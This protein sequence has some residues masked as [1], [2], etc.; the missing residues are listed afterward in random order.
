MPQ[1]RQKENTEESDFSTRQGAR[2][3]CENQTMGLT[4]SGERTGCFPP[5]PGLSHYPSIFPR[6]R[7]QTVEM[8]RRQCQRKKDAHLREEGAHR[9]SS[10]AGRERRQHIA[11]Q[12]AAYP[13]FL[14]RCSDSA[15]APGQILQ[16]SILLEPRIAPS[17]GGRCLLRSSKLEPVLSRLKAPA[18]AT[19]P[20]EWER[21]LKDVES[22]T[23]QGHDFRGLEESDYGTRRHTTPKL[24][25]SDC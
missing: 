7:S 24:Y 23:R 18:V 1:A 22:I 19:K 16:L 8:L 17:L 9:P 10:D 12:S 21:L 11:W 2:K 13:P 3:D 6:R 20:T 5:S 15:S 4:A 25:T 14:P